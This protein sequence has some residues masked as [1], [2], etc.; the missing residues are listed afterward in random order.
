MKKKHL[1]VKHPIL[2][3]LYKNF[4]LVA[5]IALALTLMANPLI[6]GMIPFGFWKKTST[7][8]C[9]FTA[10]TTITDANR[11]S[12]GN[13]HWDIASGVVVTINS[14]TSLSIGNL[15]MNGGGSKIQHATCTT[16]TCPQVGLN[17]TGDATIPAGSSINVDAVG[18][19]GG[20]QSSVAPAT[21]T[22]NA[23][24]TGITYAFTAGANLTGG[25]S[26]GGW[27]GWNSS[28][29]T[30]VPGK[31]FEDPKQPTNPGGGG[32]ANGAGKTGGNGGGVIKLIVSGTLSLDGTLS[33]T[34]GSSI[35]G[36]GA[37]GSIWIQANT[38]T[39]TTTGLLISANGGTGGIAGSGQ[40]GSSR[41]AGGGGGGRI[42][43]YYGSLG[44]TFALNSTFVQAYGGTQPANANYYGGSGT[45]YAKSTSQTQGDLYIY[46]PNN[47]KYTYNGTPIGIYGWV[48]FVSSAVISYTPYIWSL[49]DLELFGDLI[50][51]ADA[52]TLNRLLIIGNNPTSTSISGGDMTTMTAA[53]RLWANVQDRHNSFDNVYISD[54][55]IV[56]TAYLNVT[57]QLTVSNTAQLVAANITAATVTLNDTSVLS[58]FAPENNYVGRLKVTATNMTIATGAKVDVS[59]LGYL[60]GK[61]SG[62]RTTNSSFYG[63]TLGLTTTGGSANDTGGSHAGQGGYDESASWK[64]YFPGT[65]YGS[66]KEPITSGGGGGTNSSTAAGN[67][68]GVVYLNISTTLTIE[69]VINAKGN[70]GGASGVDGGAG[71]GGSIWISAPSITAV[72]AGMK[73]NA[74]GGNSGGDDGG[75][76]GHIA[77]YYFTLGGVVSFAS[78]RIS[79]D[80]GN[81]WS[82]ATN[83]NAGT[84]Y[85]FIIG[86]STQGDLYLLDSNYS[87]FH[88]L[89]LSPFGRVTSTT[90]TTLVDSSLP[91]RGRDFYFTKDQVVG[92]TLTV[93]P[94]LLNTTDYTIN[95]YDESTG[96]FTLSGNPSGVANSSYWFIKGFNTHF[97]NFYIYGNTLLQTPYLNATNILTSSGA[98]TS[99]T[100][101]LRMDTTTMNLNAGNGKIS[102]WFTGGTSAPPMP[103]VINAQTVTVGNNWKISAASGGYTGAN[104]TWNVWTGR[105]GPFCDNNTNYG[106]TQGNTA[107]GGPQYG[108]GGSHTSYGGRLSGYIPATPYGDALQPFT[109]GGGG[110]GDTTN[111]LYWG[112]TGGG[113]LVLNV[114]GTLTINGL[115]TVEPDDTSGG[116]YSAGA[117][118]SLW[119]TA[120]TIATARSASTK[121]IQ[122]NASYTSKS[123]GA[124]G[125]GGRVALYY[126]NLTTVNINNIVYSGSTGSSGSGGP[127]NGGAGSV[128]FKP[129]SGAGALYY[130]NS[131]IAPS[132][133]ETP[134]P[135]YN[136]TLSR[137]DVTNNA[138]VKQVSNLNTIAV[139]GTVS[140]LYTGSMLYVPNNGTIDNT[141]PWTWFTYSS[142]SGTITEY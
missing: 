4:L 62:L 130:D 65:S 76:G 79:A 128:Y 56:H 88:N 55:S 100:G 15:V 123:N 98:S 3:N 24:D 72:T 106:F 94:H 49:V 19:L 40:C 66:I 113:V 112:G 42:A 133:L 57:S 69:G 17:V 46:G 129:S 121:I 53:G 81:G 47:S 102:T 105:E 68:G 44:G 122:C 13:C 9:S 141:G 140:V 86:S 5:A 135:A 95:D 117:G 96:T 70:A 26:H 127:G 78:N 2:R 41:P 120:N 84:I 35:C 104:C 115:L 71:A 45:I 29:A 114:T 6:A 87:T 25:G 64:A 89:I 12:F 83:G 20:R 60:G 142:K 61:R 136:V 1:V 75:G 118:G 134:L 30:H 80:G 73:I 139:S 52:M 82:T 21:V 131:G 99:R 36:A 54:A 126:T 32:G 110:G 107:T 18:Y 138:L 103:L 74:S 43:I 38:I 90:S 111:F 33:A 67:G 92:K 28:Q 132:Y 119:I 22:T 97:D 34:G 8:T 58:H 124:G 39:S 23:A 7:G 109:F 93:N 125:S 37:G 101:F 85:G 11:S 31:P 16:T 91:T 10:N 59:G 51:D 50:P 137:L 48:D 27:G 108:A 63:M 77:I 14:S 116:G